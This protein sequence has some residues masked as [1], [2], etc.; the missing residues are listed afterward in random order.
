MA[1]KRAN[2]EG[3]LRQRKDG[4]W[5]GRLTVGRDMGTGKLIRK[6]YYASTQ[7][8]LKKR[9]TAASHA[10][11]EGEFYEPSKMTMS[12][13]LDAW[14]KDYNAHLKRYTLDNYNSK[15][16]NHLKPHIGAVKV[17]ELSPA[18]VNQLYNKLLITL[19]TKSVR[20]IH[21]ILHSAME[22]LV[23]IGERKDNPC[24]SSAKRLPK[25]ARREMLVLADNDLK[26]FMQVIK[27]N[28]YENLF[29]VDVFTGMRQGEILG[30]RWSCV[31]FET[32][33]IT[34]DK[35]LYM[36]EKGGRYTLESLKNNKTR[37][38]CAAPFVMEVLKRVRKE[39]LE[40]RIRAGH[41]W[42]CGYFPD[43]VFT[44]DT[45]RHFTHKTTYKQFKR[46]VE[47]TGVPAV[48]FHDMRHTFATLSLQQNKGDF[49]TVK[50]A[51]GHAT[52]AY[53]LDT[54]AHVTTQMQR[55]SADGLERLIQSVK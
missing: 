36:P 32:G 30:L 31:D 19:A 40:A 21:G 13:W 44:H 29:L 17:S 54:Y 38:I 41:L 15:I 53:T 46:M 25:V 10:V 43:L 2:G 7:A 22:T 11:D 52:A 4:K 26:K 39:Q 16:K 5:E 27:G 3:N 33:Y 37:T 14:I 6:S 1:G 55:E 49:K 12:A 8:E 48:R 50:E 47:L 9:M 23:D 18:I 35:Q 45:G 20:S 24:A 42:D 34:V 51:M 28:P